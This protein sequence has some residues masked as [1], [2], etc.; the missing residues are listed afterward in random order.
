MH[1]D[2]SDFSWNGLI[3]LM[4]SES[5]DT[6]EV[7]H[8][9]IIHSNFV[10]HLSQSLHTSASFITSFVE[11]EESFNTIYPTS[12]E[13]AS[14]KFILRL[15]YDENAIVDSTYAKH[16]MNA[17]SLFYEYTASNDAIPFFVS[18]SDL[19]V[20]TLNRTT[21]DGIY[22]D[23]VIKS[24]LSTSTVR[25]AKTRGYWDGSEWSSD[26]QYA[27]QRIEFF[28]SNS[29]ELS[30]NYVQ[31]FM[32][33]S[34]SIQDNKVTSIRHYGIVYGSSLTHL[35]LG[36]VGGHATLELPTNDQLDL[37][38]SDE[39]LYPSK[40]YHEFSTSYIKQN[41]LAKGVY[42]TE[43]IIS[44]SGEIINYSDLTAGDSVKSFYI[45]GVTNDEELQ[46]HYI[47]ISVPGNTLP[48]GS[49][50]TSSVVIGEPQ[51]VSMYDNKLIEIQVSGS[52]EKN[53]LSA[54]VV[55]LSY[56]SS[57]NE[58]KFKP[59][60]ELVPG[61]DYFFDANSNKISLISSSVLFL[62]TN[63]G[64]FYEMDVE[65]EDNFILA[66]DSLGSQETMLTLIVHN[67][68]KPIL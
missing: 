35:S 64:S 25:F 47:D 43:K 49:H 51:V 18:S 13:D 55:V 42:E 9:P 41:A 57:S 15:A 45:P 59:V 54:D 31:N 8:K 62:N 17:L 29:A 2:S 39:Y 32:I 37:D 65:T 5:I 14:N 24:Q 38:Y 3:D 1:M 28:V 68:L 4:Q 34:S 44:A 6:V 48:S 36:T 7:V 53:Y 30:D 12:V 46:S 19:W 66:N 61:D 56:V 10:N 22:P 67:R 23:L 50:Y 60:F 16:D 26:S 21:N 40:H 27:N 20:D 63:T 33:G 52:G 58:F 11:H